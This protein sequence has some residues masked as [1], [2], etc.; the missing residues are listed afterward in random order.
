MHTF[1]ASQSIGE[2]VTALPKAS[3]IFREYNID[4]CCGGHR[5]LSEAVRAQALNEQEILEKLEEACME[6][7]NLTEGPD[8]GKMP[9]EAL[10]DY[11]VSTHHAFL[12]RILPEL[13]ELTAR[14]LRVHG[15][16]HRNLFEVYK[17]FHGL[18][19]ELEQH[20]VKEEEILF[21]MLKQYGSTP[22]ER[23]LNDIGKVMAETEGEHETAGTVLKEL[24]KVTGEYTVPEDGCETY[25]LTF[26]K[27]EELEADLFQHIHL[28][29]NILFKEVSSVAL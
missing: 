4:F 14:L 28:E 7:R 23:I 6:T 27:L 15:P 21:P 1:T 26:H 5:N 10:I 16:R 22:S 13:G 17:L 20:L 9:P 3:D 29:N 2:I 11:I 12:K 19:V 8:F 18:K 25:R 24:R